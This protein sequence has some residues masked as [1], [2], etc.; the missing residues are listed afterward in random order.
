MSAQHT[1]E[2]ARFNNVLFSALD[3]L[4][5]SK[6]P[7]A[8]IGGVA[9]SGMGR[10][11]STHDIDV[12][13]APEDAEAILRALAKHGFRTEKYDIEWLFKAFKD[14]ILVDIIFRSKGDI[15]F[16]EEMQAHRHNVEFHGRQIPM[17]SPED[18]AIIKCAVHYEGGPHHW[19]DALAI[20]S[21]ASIDWNYLLR[22][23]RR[24]PRRLLALL[25]YA[26]SSDIL[27]PNH[28]IHHLYEYVFG[29][30]TQDTAAKVTPLR[31]PAQPLHISESP[32]YLVARIC[33]ALREDGRTAQQDLHVFLNGHQVVVEGD[34]PSDASRKG[35]AEVVSRAAPG[36]DIDNRVRVASVGAPERAEVIS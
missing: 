23:A 17:V 15:Y 10:P 25:I 32:D 26:Q 2:G 12:F 1:E 36:H 34:A 7:F 30:E 19:H 14:D 21:H 8:L 13:V 6:I 5:E 18:L 35:V 4:E 31:A 22:R 20:L 29:N 16:D 28:V 24:A 9:A 27:I 3:A 33:E 11:R